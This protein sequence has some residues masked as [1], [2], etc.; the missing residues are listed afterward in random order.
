MKR[1]LSQ[2]YLPQDLKNIMDTKIRQ[3]AGKGDMSSQA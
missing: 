2:F 1:S 3:R